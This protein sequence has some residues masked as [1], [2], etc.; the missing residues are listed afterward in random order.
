LGLTF[1]DLQ[2]MGVARVSLPVSLLLA[3]IH[4]MRRALSTIRDRDGTG[5]DPDLY[6][7]FTDMHRLVGMEE[8]YAREARF[9]DPKYL[10]REYTATG[11]TR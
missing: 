4:A 10:D 2:A 1:T 3:S 8:V 11:G 5:I 9:L 7:D 6:A